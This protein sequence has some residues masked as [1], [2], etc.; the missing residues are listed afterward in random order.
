VSSTACVL[1]ALKQLAGALREYKEAS[2]WC[3]RRAV[4]I[5]D[6]GVALVPMLQELEKAVLAPGQVVELQLV[7]A[8]S[9]VLVLLAKVCPPQWCGWGGCA[10]VL[11][12]LAQARQT[13]L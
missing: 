12:L 3:K 1:Q 9:N 8:L 11:V 5:G 2:I 4:R 13:A 6:R 10:V 7:E